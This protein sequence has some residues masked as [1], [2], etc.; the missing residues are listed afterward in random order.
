M[1]SNNNNNNEKTFFT[2]EIINSYVNYKLNEL[3]E[4]KPI[5]TSLGGYE[6]LN[7][8]QFMNW[9][10]DYP[11]GLNEDIEGSIN[12]SFTRIFTSKCQD[13][14]PGYIDGAI[15]S[16]RNNSNF[17]VLFAVYN[18]SNIIL[19]NENPTANDIEEYQSLKSNSVG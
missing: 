18:K 2:D 1:D 12:E 16:L 3:N 14:N 15:D 11:N 17:D 10:N 19:L 9:W 4:V 13:L 8:K 5:Q 6:L 7:Y